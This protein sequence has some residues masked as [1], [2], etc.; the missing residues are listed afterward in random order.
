[1]RLKLDKLF[2]I[3]CD[4]IIDD[5]A[6]CYG[7]LVD[8]EFFI[9]LWQWENISNIIMSMFQFFSLNVFIFREK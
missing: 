8:Y 5:V 3:F 6:I 2:N 4:L 1:M 9:L 7:V